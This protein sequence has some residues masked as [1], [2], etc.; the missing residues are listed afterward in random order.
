MCIVFIV[1]T[2]KGL[3]LT[4]NRDENLSRPASRFGVYEDFEKNESSITT[5]STVIIEHTESK[6]NKDIKENQISTTKDSIISSKSSSIYYCKDDPT[7]GTFFAINKN[8]YNFCFLLNHA[9][10][11]FPYSP[12]KTK[13]RGQIPLLFCAIDINDGGFDQSLNKFIKIL[14]END[15]NYNGYNIVF[16]NLK[17]ER[18]FY[19]TNNREYLKEKEIKVS[20]P[21]EF[22][23]ED[24]CY[25]VS[26]WSLFEKVDKCEFGIKLIKKIIDKIE[27]EEKEQKK[28]QSD[29]ESKCYD[30]SYID[31]I[32]NLVVDEVMFNNYRHIDSPIVFEEIKKKYLDKS[33]DIDELSIKC[34]KIDK[35]CIKIRSYPEIKEF[36]DSSI[37]VDNVINNVYFDLGTR[38]N[39]FVT[40]LKSE[41]KILVRERFAEIIQTE[42]DESVICIDQSLNHITSLNKVDF[43]KSKIDHFV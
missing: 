7:G 32:S 37:F 4:F 33:K 21:I 23:F 9:G 3:F 36:T 43:F 35:V 26:N 5:D 8:T 27:I 12:L 15:S 13:L 6:F 42:A 1:K 30:K 22:N 40:Y 28:D 19:Y 18:V 41:G 20:F 31:V 14:E 29:S 34:I 16:G 25:A 38:Q 2:K 10:K 24:Q 39:Y 17:L 11:S